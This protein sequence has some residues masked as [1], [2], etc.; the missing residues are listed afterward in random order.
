[1]CARTLT[2]KQGIYHSPHTVQG[3]EGD[4]G[5]GEGESL[6]VSPQ[7]TSAPTVIQR[8]KGLARVYCRHLRLHSEHEGLNPAKLF[9]LFL[10][11]GAVTVCETV[12]LRHL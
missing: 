4:K 6:A 9:L 10:G 2:Q 5:G 11:E 7:G 8:N 12:H 1:M 3:G